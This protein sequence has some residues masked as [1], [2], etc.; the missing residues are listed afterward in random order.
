MLQQKVLSD[1]LRVL[2]ESHVNDPCATE[3]HVA[4]DRCC[5]LQAARQKQ[6]HTDIQHPSLEAPGQAAEIGSV[7]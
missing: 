4:E 3:E 7:T 2:L 5:R 6:L 1:H